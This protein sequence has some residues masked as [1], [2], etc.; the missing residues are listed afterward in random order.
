MFNTFSHATKER[1]RSGFEDFLKLLIVIDPLPLEMEEFLEL[2]DHLWVATDA[3]QTQPSTTAAP[4]PASISPNT[5][6]QIQQNKPPPKKSISSDS[7]IHEPLPPLDQLSPLLRSSYLVMAAIYFPCILAG[8]IDIT[9]S[10]FGMTLQCMHLSLRLT[11]LSNYCFR[12]YITDISISGCYID[13][14]TSKNDKSQ[15]IVEHVV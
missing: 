4:S 2:D 3:T 8:V 14:V 15:E 6:P 9:Q 5:Q 13:F 10:S 1:R 7:L 12:S 11:L